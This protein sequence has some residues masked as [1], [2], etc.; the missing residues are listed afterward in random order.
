MPGKPP[1]RGQCKQEKAIS[2]FQVVG[3]WF[4]NSWSHF[5]RTQYTTQPEVIANFLYDFVTFLVAKSSS[6]LIHKH[7]PERQEK[8]EKNE[9]ALKK[10]YK[11]FFSTAVKA[12]L[13]LDTE[14]CWKVNASKLW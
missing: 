8:S 2:F 11:F 12:I 1:T 9:F 5:S 10:A 13:N 14:M 4:C 3:S 6:S 7:A